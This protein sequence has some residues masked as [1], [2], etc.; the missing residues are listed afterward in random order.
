MVLHHLILVESVVSEPRIKLAVC[1][2]DFPCMEV[3]D[4]NIHVV[5]GSATWLSFTVPG[6]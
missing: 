4:P 3:S 1:E 2:V 6:S 5:K